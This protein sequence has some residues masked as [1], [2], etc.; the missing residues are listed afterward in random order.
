MTITVVV[1]IDPSVAGGT[2]LTNDAETSTTTTETNSDDNTDTVDVEVLAVADLGVTKT[3][4]V[5]TVIAGESLTYTITATNAGPSDAQNVVISDTVPANLT[6]SSVT[7][8]ADCSIVGNVITCTTSTVAYDDD[9]VVTIA[10]TVSEDAGDGSTI[11]NT[12]S[13]ASDTTDDNPDDNSAT[14]ETEVEKSVDLELSKTSAAERV[15]AGETLLYNLEISNLGPSSATNVV[16][17]DILPSGVTFNS[18]MSNSNCTETGGVGTCSFPTIASDATV[19]FVIAVDLPTDFTDGATLSNSASV[20]ANENDPNEDNNSD[21]DEITVDN[22]ADLSIVKNAEGSVVAGE[23]ISWTID[24][25]NAG[26]SD[27][28]NVVITDT[29]PLGA[30]FNTASSDGRCSAAGQTVTCTIAAMAADSTDSFVIDV[31]VASSVADM[32]TLSNGAEIASDTDDPNLDDNTSSDDVPV[33]RESDLTIVKTDLA[34]PVVAGGQIQWSIAVTNNGPSDADNVTITDALPTGFSFVSVDDATNCSAPANTVNCLFPTVTN[35]STVTVVITADIDSDLADGSIHTNTATA[36][37]DSSEP[38]SATE[39]TSVQRESDLGITKT[40]DGAVVAG[41]NQTYTIEVTNNGP[42]DAANVVVTDAL[43]AGISFVSDSLSACSAAGAVV[44]C[45]LATLADQAVLSFDLIVAVSD[46]ATNPTVNVVKANSDSTDPTTDNNTADDSTDITFEADLSMTKSAEP[47]PATPGEEIT[48]TLVVTNSGPSIAN[49]VVVTDILPSG[50]TFASAST[51]CSHTAGTVTCSAVS[52]LSGAQATFTITAALDSSLTG[53]VTNTASVDSDTPDPNPDDNSATDETPLTPSADLSVLKESSADPV[54]AGEQMTYTIVVSNSGP[55]NAANIVVTDVLPAG[56]TVVAAD[57]SGDCSVAGQSVTCS[58]SSLAVNADYVVTL[59]ADLNEE[60]AQGSTITNTASVS[61]DTPDPDPDNDSSTEETSVAKSADL[62]ITKAV[63]VTTVSAGQQLIYGVT[64]ANNGPSSATNIVITDT[65][66][67]GVVYNSAQSSASCAEASGVVTCTSP[68]LNSD[69]TIVFNIVVDL[70]S[71]LLDAST[72]VNQIA[73]TADESDPSPDNNEDTDEITLT[74]LADLSIVKDTDGFVVAGQSI[75]WDLNVFNS[76]HS[77]AVNVVIS[78]TLPAGTTFD[79]VASDPRCSAAS[80]I[81]TC[82]LGTVA[83]DT[84]DVVVISVNAD[85]SLPDLGSIANTASISSD[86]EDPDPE[87]NSSTD[88]VPIE[89]DSGL[90]IAK[91][92]LS[93]PVVAGQQVQW[94]IL[95]SNAG[96]SDADN[97]AVTDSAP[98]GFTV[99]TVDNNVNCAIAGNTVNC[100]FPVIASGDNIEIVVTADVDSEL[101]DGSNHVNTATATSD[102]SETVEDSEDTTSVR[103]SDL[104]ISKTSDRAVVAGTQ[105]QYEITVSNQGPSDADNVVITDILPTGVT[106]VSDTVAAEL[107]GATCSPVLGTVVC[108]MGTVANNQTVTFTLVVAVAD[109]AGDVAANVVTIDSDSS[110]PNPDNNTGSDDTTVSFEADLAVTK[111]ASP[112]PAI[113]GQPITW[114]LTVANSGPSIANNVVLTDV[115]PTGTSIVSATVGCSEASG[116]V[117]CSADALAAGEQLSFE[118]VADI[119]ANHVDAI[120]NTAKATSDTPD[121]NPGD[122]EATATTETGASAD[123]SLTKSVLTNPVVAGQEAVFELTVANA[124]PSDALD[125]IVTDELPPGFTFV[126]ADDGCTLSDN[127]AGAGSSNGTVDCVLPMLASGAT[128][129]IQLAVTVDS[130]ITEGDIVTNTASVTAATPDAD[131]T[132]N[133]GTVDVPVTQQAELE[134]TK[135]VLTDDP[136]IGDVVEWL[137]EVSNVGPSQATNVMALDQIDPSFTNVQTDSTDC[138]VVSNDVSCSLA[139]LASG[140]QWSTTISAIATNDAAGDRVNVVQVTSDSTDFVSG[141]ALYNIRIPELDLSLTKISS[142]IV[143]SVGDMVEWLIV[144]ENNGEPT[145]SP[146]LISD[147]VEATQQVVTVTSSDATCTNQAN[148]IECTIPAGFTG[149]AE[150][151]VTTEVLD[152]SG[153][154]TNSAVLTVENGPTSE[155]EQTVGSADIERD[156]DPVGPLAFTG[157]RSIATGLF[158]TALLLIGFALVRTGRRRLLTG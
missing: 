134:V 150:I 43:P 111:T 14:D 22:Q 152:V 107:S 145:A 102:S 143:R 46:D 36:A 101:A 112:D 119:D 148:E 9:Y 131:P 3:S 53:S 12:A 5:S 88:S 105:H 114:E 158:A 33:S 99:V 78:D 58:A 113:P 67:A 17:T 127:A 57:P 81:V 41:T 124:G 156:E 77:D 10:T 89:R 128:H 34:D 116:V 71:S 94:S 155:T 65:L 129:S 95:V 132:S 48:W 1:D 60:T 28:V 146:A 44:T 72:L 47:D 27:A 76:G 125:V 75:A 123:L 13:V 115:L 7:P 117:T 2:T 8:A 35:G 87:D 93:D 79:P 91:T 153:E 83:A 106:Y 55:S 80:A 30:T 38:V 66:P 70:P 16:V 157:S 52:I 154:I 97:V 141:S 56:L 20:E 63:G 135:T 4:D 31:D 108:D 151:A 42:S 149:Q 126:W 64:L 82:N 90:S 137:V 104:S 11:S 122:N 26:P 121:S 98:P 84:A 139:T 144:V 147:E 110:D 51:G 45:N 133:E 86:T 61:S 142:D 39:D 6:I 49:N 85:S 69:Q 54:T 24:I 50:T 68:V 120:I 100:A 136:K 37:S 103:S 92:D 59:V 130:T 62:E 21:T 73:V 138:V 29:L 96:P 40:S 74:N 109:A 140:A 118:I 19:A 32:A 25:A 18:T 15:A 23:S